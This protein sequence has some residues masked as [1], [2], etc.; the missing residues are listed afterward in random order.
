MVEEMPNKEHRVYV[1][2]LGS[3]IQAGNSLETS[4]I[5]R[6]YTISFAAP[7]VLLPKQKVADYKSDVWSVGCLLFFIVTATNPWN[8]KTRV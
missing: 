4:K 2:D 3:G 7:E 5:A 1:I 8:S 6:E